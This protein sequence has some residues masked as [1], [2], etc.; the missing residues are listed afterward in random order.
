MAFVN[1]YYTPEDAKQYHLKE[2]DANYGGP[3]TRS[4]SWTVDRERGYYLRCVERCREE[5]LGQLVFDLHW[6]RRLL[7]IRL[8]KQSDAVRGGPGW[9]HYGLLRIDLVD[10]DFRRDWRFEKIHPDIQPLLGE[11]LPVLKEALT[12]YADSGIRS[13]T[14]SYTATF[15]F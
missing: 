4:D 13:A 6:K 8:T 5:A 14:T 15:D 2:V 11:I 9:G 1:E 7:R 12:T 3:A 10:A